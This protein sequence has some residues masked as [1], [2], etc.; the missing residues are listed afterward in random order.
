MKLSFSA[1]DELFRKEV[2]AWLNDNLVGEFTQLRI[3][4]LW[5]AGS[6]GSHW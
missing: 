6:R 4:S 2:A 1:E 3:R 5:C